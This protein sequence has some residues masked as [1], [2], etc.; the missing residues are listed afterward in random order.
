MDELVVDL[1][2]ATDVTC[3]Q[4]GTG[5]DDKRYTYN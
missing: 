3:G 5:S 2:N 4:G 1:G